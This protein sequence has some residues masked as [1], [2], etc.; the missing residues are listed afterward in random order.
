MT[1]SIVVPAY[2]EERSIGTVLDQLRR[3]MPDAEVV[4]VDDGSSDGTRNIAEARGVRVLSHLRN[5]GYGAA[6]KTGVRAATEDVVVFFDADGQHNV[7]EIE[8]MV[9]QLKEA[10]MVVAERVNDAAVAGWR[11]VGKWVLW[12]AFL[13]LV[14]VRMQDINCGLRAF[15]RTTLLRYL[16]LLPNGFSFSTTSSIVYLKFGHTVMFHPIRVQRRVGKSTVRP[17]ADGLNTLML[18]LRLVTLF[19]PL[20]VF[21][22]LAAALVTVGCFYG[23]YKFFQVGLGIPGGAI[24]LILFGLVCFLLG[25]VC[26]QIAALR[27]E[28]YRDD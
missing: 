19:A 24:V 3:A 27:L 21:L 28:R 16:P 23:I 25:V 5:R 9:A 14:G 10:E 26:D 22:P 1:I 20:R 2:N 13:V 6:L 15:R 4:V 18:I 12:L 7:D 11:W 17:I 8:P